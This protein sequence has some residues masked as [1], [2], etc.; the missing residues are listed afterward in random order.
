M[1]PK[2]NVKH[3]RWR[4]NSYVFQVGEVL[5]VVF[6]SEALFGL[7]NT[8]KFRSIWFGRYDVVS[9]A[10]FLPPEYIYIIFMYILDIV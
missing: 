7:K 6:V 4:E 2:F 3:H 10:C 8:S 1:P 9:K 5:F